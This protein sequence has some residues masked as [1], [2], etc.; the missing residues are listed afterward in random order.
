MPTQID[1]ASLIFI[2]CSSNRSLLPLLDRWGLTC[3][4]LAIPSNESNQ[5][6]I[7]GPPPGTLHS[8][9]TIHLWEITQAQQKQQ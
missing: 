3:Q 5:L 4:S 2:V 7:E 1:H 6:V 8:D 9:C